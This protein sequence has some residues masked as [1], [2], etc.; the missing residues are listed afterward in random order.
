MCWNAEVSLQS[1]LLGSIGIIIGLIYGLSYPLL[2]FYSTIVCMQLFEFI[3]WSN[4][5]NNNVRF[6]IS[7]FAASL[8]ELQPIASI[9]TLYPKQIMYNLLFLYVILITISNIYIW[10][11]LKEP[12]NTFF[13]MY[14]A[15]NGHLAWNWLKKDKYTLISIFIYIIFLFLPLIIMKRWNFIIYGLITLGVSIYLFISENTWGSIWCW[16]VNLSIIYIGL[17]KL[18]S[19]S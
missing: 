16:L 9:L 10:K 3:I 14:P 1:F 4:L 7:I 8:L 17:N 6:I 15:K 12:L 13:D 18:W 5:D 11:N 2:F 19:H